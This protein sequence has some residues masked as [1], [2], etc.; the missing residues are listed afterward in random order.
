V[1]PAQAFFGP[2][3]MIINQMTGSGVDVLPWLF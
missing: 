3:M 2:Q 1:D